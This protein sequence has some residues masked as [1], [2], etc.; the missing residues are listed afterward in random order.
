MI[1]QRNDIWKEVGMVVV[2][3]D[4]FEDAVDAFHDYLDYIREE[5]ADVIVEIWE[6]CNCVETDDDMRYIFI[7]KRFK[8]VFDK[9]ND[10]IFYN[11]FSI[12]LGGSPKEL[13]Y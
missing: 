7:D 4:S 10:V 5:T 6:D 3:C 11:E 8:G 13:Y 2:L 1:V 12:S 9:N